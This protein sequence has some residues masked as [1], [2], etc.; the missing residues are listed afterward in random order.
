MFLLGL[1]LIHIKVLWTFF[2]PFQKTAKPLFYDVNLGLGCEANLVLEIISL[3]FLLFQAIND[4]DS[5]CKQSSKDFEAEKK[6][7]AYISSSLR[8]NLTQEEPF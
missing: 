3:K 5:T 1:M 2:V 7:R 6:I 8:G 4:P